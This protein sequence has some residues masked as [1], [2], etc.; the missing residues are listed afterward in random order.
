MGVDLGEEDFLPCPQCCNWD[1][2]PKSNGL[3][4][5]F[6][7]HKDYPTSATDGSPVP[8]PEGRDCFEFENGSRLPFIKLD[9]D[10]MKQACRFAFY[11]ASRPKGAWTKATTSCHLRHCGISTGLAE[12]VHELA[13]TCAKAKEQDLINYDDPKGIGKF[14]FPGPWRSS[15]ISLRDCVE[16]IMH[17]LFLGIAESNYELISQFLTSVPS[18]AK[19]SLSPFKNAPQELIK[20]LRPFQLSW[21][22]AH[23]LTGKKGHLGTGS[24]VAENWVFFTR[25]SQFMHGWCIK[26]CESANKCGVDDMS[27]MVIAFHALAARCLTHAGIDDD[28][29]SH[30]ELH[31][32]EFSSAVREFDIRVR[33]KQLNGPAS[34][35]SD[36]KKTEA[37]WLKPNYMSLSDLLWMMALLGPLV[38]WWDGGGKGER[39]IQVV[40]PHI[41]RGVREDV[42]S[43][44]VTP[45]EKLYQGIHLEVMEKRLGISGEQ[46][47]LGNDDSGQSSSP[48][49]VLRDIAGLLA[50]E[51]VDKENDGDATTQC[52][53]DSEE[54]DDEDVV[55]DEAH[56]GTNETIGMTKKRTIYVC[57]NEKALKEAISDKKP[58]AGMVQVV[59]SNGRT[60]FEFEVVF[61][62]PVKILARRR[63]T[64]EDLT[65]V[66]HHGLWCAKIHVEDEFVQSALF[67]D[68]Q[69]AAKLSAVAIP[70]WCIVGKQHAHADKYCVITNWWRYRMCDGGYR[71]PTVDAALCGGTFRPKQA[72]ATDSGDDE[73]GIP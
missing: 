38:L 60:V 1:F 72:R 27:R 9:W 41:K 31:M 69:S 47:Q 48:L 44:F 73:F 24:W 55:A 23:P 58:L 71:L 57:R 42:L 15:E 36:K 7:R 32:K 16:A 2:F 11:Q 18:A 19:L 17:Q 6:P 49:E 67:A 35:S 43:F 4:L 34:K 64:F 68:I 52:G 8:P 39:F 46:Q 66:S 33:H 63:V 13:K 20:D 70:L 50:P 30:T 45:L 59:K 22:A 54:E 25:V 28:F 12:L 14:K 53:A 61:R 10:M 62:E 65:G 21:L 29:I 56:F 5:T 40:K 26:D 51:D 37:W 3:N